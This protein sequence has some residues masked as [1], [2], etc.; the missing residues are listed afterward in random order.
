[1]CQRSCMLLNSFGVHISTRTL[2]KSCG[3]VM[4]DNACVSEIIFL[5]CSIIVLQCNTLLKKSKRGGG[6]PG[7]V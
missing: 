5:D 6:Q 3:V 2:S 4:L 1:M 7:S